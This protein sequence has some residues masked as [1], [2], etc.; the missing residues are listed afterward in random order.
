MEDCSHWKWIPS[1]KRTNNS[2]KSPFYSWVT[3]LFRLGHF[4]VR[5]LLVYQRVP[6]NITSHFQGY[7]RLSQPWTGPQVLVFSWLQ[8]GMDDTFGVQWRSYVKSWIKKQE[9]CRVS[10]RFWLKWVYIYIHIHIYIYIYTY[11]Y[12]YIHIHIYIYIHIHNIYIYVHS[13]QQEY[14]YS[15]RVS[16]RLAFFFCKV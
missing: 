14:T 6:H 15:Y 9:T 10:I 8:W 1:G 4:Q 12:I 13:I 2:G 5:K 3:Q 11:I 7:H 16:I